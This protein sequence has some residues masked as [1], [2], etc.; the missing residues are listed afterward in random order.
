M[1]AAGRLVTVWLY[2][3]ENKM[4]WMVA[5]EDYLTLRISWIPAAFGA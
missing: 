4:V 5:G 1:D 2:P 3:E